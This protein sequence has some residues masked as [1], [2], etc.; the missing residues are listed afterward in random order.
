MFHLLHLNS[1]WSF[2][3]DHNKSCVFCVNYKHVTFYYHVHS[4]IDNGNCFLAVI[5]FIALVFIL[6]F[7]SKVILIT[8]S[9]NCS[10]TANYD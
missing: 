5:M 3:H 8:F 4:S 9:V 1:L 2:I 10:F 7:S 6:F